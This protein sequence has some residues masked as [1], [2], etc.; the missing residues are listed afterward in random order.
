MKRVSYRSVAT[1]AATAVLGASA[2]AASR[3]SGDLGS[4]AA[5][6]AKATKETLIGDGAEIAKLV[7]DSDDLD[8][9]SAFRAP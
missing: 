4:V 8:V 1:A 2:K 3:L 5:D 6:A 9:T 7:D